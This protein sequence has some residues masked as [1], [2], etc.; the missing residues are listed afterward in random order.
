VRLLFTTQKNG[1]AGEKI[2]HGCT[3]DHLLCPTRAVA[4]L[5]KHLR[6]LQA[7]RTTPLHC[8]DPVTRLSV[9]ARHITAALR[10]AARLAHPTTGIDPNKL[11]ARSLRPGGAT[12][13]L[14]AQIDSDTIKLVGRWKSDAMLRYLH[15]QAFPALGNLAH[16][17]FRHGSFTFLPQHTQP[18][19]ATA[20]IDIAAALRPGHGPRGTPS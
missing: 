13:L 12:A 7:P 15:A 16:A 3:G 1:T 19:E 8:T 20:V 17:M 10:H 18:V 14:C 5:A 2:A 4:R 6:Q 9:H 11:T